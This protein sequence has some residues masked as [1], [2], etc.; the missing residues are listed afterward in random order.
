MTDGDPAESK[1]VGRTVGVSL[2]YN[3][4]R[5]PDTGEFTSLTRPQ[6]DAARKRIEAFVTMVLTES[7]GPEV[8][9]V[10]CWIRGV[11]D[12]DELRRKLMHVA[13]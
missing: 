1:D 7:L 6:I 10:N 13:Q 5:D 4:K 11:T 2:I 3:Q 9:A 8:H 12:A